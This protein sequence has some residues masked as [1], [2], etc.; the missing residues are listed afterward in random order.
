MDNNNTYDYIIAGMG[1]AGL[2]L[3]VQLLHS[4]VKFEK[5]LLI[6]KSTKQHNDRTWCF[7]TKEQ[8]EWYEPIVYKSWEKFKVSLTSFSES[9]EL[10][11]YQYKLI[12][13]ID[14][15]EYCLNVINNDKRF[16][17]VYDTIINIK[18]ENDKA[19]LQTE[20]I[21]YIANYVFN[22]AIVNHY[23]KSQDVNYVQHFKGWVIETNT[24]CFNDECPTF[25]DFSIEQH[26]D[27][28]FVYIIPHNKRKALIEYTGFSPKSISDTEYD[29]F[30]KQY[31][32][33]KLN[34]KN[35]SITEIE[36]GEIP[37]AESE[38]TN[39]FGNRVVNIGT[40]GGYSKPSTGYTFY[41][42]Q[43]YVSEIINQL[44]FNRLIAPP[45][46]KNKYKFFDKVLLQVI[47]DKKIP[48][49][50]VF[51]G[52]FKHNKT[53]DLLAFLNEETN[54]ITDLKIMNSVSKKTFILAALKKLF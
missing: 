1:C 4:G 30:L 7:W 33:Q 13:G 39:P 9:L 22:S 47:D 54:I 18:T 31:I 21:T 49:A 27:C 44:K 14:F 41:F 25:M 35:Y 26:N 3:A 45:I 51:A 48:A 40:A 32:E 53:K 42:I 50:E 12:R 16:T 46:Q 23:K 17:I 36:K 43:K 24:D 2:S 37:M 38:F 29:L 20:S 28:R 8:H 34:L 5:V 15:Y 10:K 52:L 19:L 6:D 11:P